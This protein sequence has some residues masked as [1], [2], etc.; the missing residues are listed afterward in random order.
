M[1]E[2]SEIGARIRRRRKEKGLVFRE[3]AELLKSNTST[4]AR[5][6]EQGPAKTKRLIAYCRALEVSPNQ[7][8]GW[9]ED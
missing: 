2:L 8:L 3:L 6:E 7:L 4:V 1:S 9:E 5:D